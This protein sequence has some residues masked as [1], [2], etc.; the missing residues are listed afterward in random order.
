M[1]LP[2]AYANRPLTFH[3]LSLL[4]SLL[5][6]EPDMSSDLRAITRALLSVSD[7]TGLIDFARA[8]SAQGVELVSTGGTRKAL[9]DA[10]A[11]RDLAKA[12]VL[13]KEYQ[14]RMV[15]FAHHFVL[16]Q[17]VYQVAVR[18]SVG[19]LNLTAAGWMAD[20]AAAK[21]A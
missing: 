8:L 1:P 9:A 7:K 20:L 14:K 3:S 6:Q 12:A 10:G 15:D 5:L 4:R 2:P 21:P 19:G 17:P 13:Y 11:E 18:K 16:V